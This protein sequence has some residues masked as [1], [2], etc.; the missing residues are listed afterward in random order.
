MFTGDRW[1]RA[2]YTEECHQLAQGIQ[3]G[4]EAGHDEIAS[5][6][7]VE[8][9]NLQLLRVAQTDHP[10]RGAIDVLFINDLV[11]GIADAVAHR[12]LQPLKQR[13]RPDE[14]ARPAPARD[15]L[16]RPDGAAD[17][18]NRQTAVAAQQRPQL[19]GIRA[20]RGDRQPAGS[21]IAINR[22]LDRFVP[23]QLRVSMPAALRQPQPSKAQ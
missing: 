11:A 12:E 23:G 6:T 18:Q 16:T 19:R 17:C 1:F 10:G 20:A 22:N 4:A 7:V 13:Q 3:V 5:G 14:R 15:Q 8:T 9:V 21:G 2:G